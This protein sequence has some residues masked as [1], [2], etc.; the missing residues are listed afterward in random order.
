MDKKNYRSCFI[1]SD[2]AI[3]TKPRCRAR[4]CVHGAPPP[5]P[6]SGLCL[7]YTGRLD[8][9]VHTRRQS[10]SRKR[11][12]A[13]GPSCSE[14]TVYIKRTLPALRTHTTC[15]LRFKEASDVKSGNKYSG[16][17]LGEENTGV[18][19]FGVCHASH[20]KEEGINKWRGM[21]GGK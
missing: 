19:S 6:P 13:L 11:G 15:N 9:H 16:L 14:S 18:I 12:A 3:N 1:T 20:E 5:P 8:K 2:F 21:R 7:H 4:V 17:L 10:Q